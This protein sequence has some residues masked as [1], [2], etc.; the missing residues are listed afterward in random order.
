MH[1]KIFLKLK[2]TPKNSS[3]FL[4]NIKKTQK[5]KTKTKKT[6]K[7]LKYPKKTKKPRKNPLGPVFYI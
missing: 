2:K 3:L 6:Q 1:L 7:N 5:P 4:A